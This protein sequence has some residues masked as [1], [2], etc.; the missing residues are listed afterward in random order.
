MELLVVIA[1]L[2]ILITVGLA[3]FQSGQRKS[4]DLQRKANLGAVARALEAYYNDTGVY[5]A[6]D[7]SGHIVISG[8]SSLLSYCDWGSSMKNSVTTYM[9][10]LPR[11][12]GVFRYWYIAGTSN[13]SYQL[14]ARLENLEDGAITV[15]NG[16]PQMYSDVSCGGKNCNYGVASSNTL[17]ETGRMYADDPG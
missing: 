14:Y 3:S 9:T 1:L 8:C 2:G 10:Q 15:N 12:P 11:D 6:D 13:A 5:P 7:G 16:E 4:K 17:P